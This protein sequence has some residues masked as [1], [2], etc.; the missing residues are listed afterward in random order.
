MSARAATATTVEWRVTLLRAAA[1]GSGAAA[2]LLLVAI[3]WLEVLARD[4][5]R[6]AESPG[7]LIVGLMGVLAPTGVGTFLALRRPANAVGW[8]L[9]RARADLGRQRPRRAV[10]QLRAARPAWS[11]SRRARGRI[12]RA[13]LM[14]LAVRPAGP[15]RA[16][17]SRRPAGLAHTQVARDRHRGHHR[18]DKCVRDPRERRARSAARWLHAGLHA[19]GSSWQSSD[20][21][22]HPRPLRLPDRRPVDIVRR[23]RRARGVERRQLTYFAY[24]ALLVPTSLGTCLLVWRPARHRHA[25]GRALARRSHRGAPGS[26]RDRDPPLPALRHRPDRQPHT[27]LRRGQ[28]TARCRLSRPRRVAHAD[29]R[30][31]RER[32]VAARHRARDGR[33]S[34]RRS[35]RCERASSASSTGI[36]RAGASRP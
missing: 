29:L 26:D 23:L 7:L 22:R 14:A 3:A 16:L 12:A 31:G 36:S 20:H 35:C 15:D 18:R 32:P 25:G 28:R 33:S 30:D 5:S 21:G 13:V 4:D 19:L 17:L 8:L 9:H 24:G 11:T 2:V 1:L 27:R 34:R 10:R 6:V